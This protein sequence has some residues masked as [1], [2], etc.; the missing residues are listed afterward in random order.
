[1]S[2]K[3]HTT[4]G[5]AHRHTL[6]ASQL[7]VKYTSENRRKKKV[8]CFHLICVASVLAPQVTIDIQQISTKTSSLSKLFLLPTSA[9]YNEVQILHITVLK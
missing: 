5:L 8:D 6:I 2:G 4:S 3:S 9:A 1:M 7:S